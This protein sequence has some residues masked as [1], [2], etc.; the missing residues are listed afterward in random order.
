MALFRLDET[1]SSGVDFSEEFTALLH[2]F[3]PLILCWQNTTDEWIP[4]LLQD[5]CRSALIEISGIKIEILNGQAVAVMFSS[6][7]YGLRQTVVKV[8]KSMIT[9]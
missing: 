5:L 9:G 3:D 2:A 6:Y 1:V 7:A 8:S 4:S